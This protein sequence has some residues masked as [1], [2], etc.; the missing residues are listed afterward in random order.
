MYS[1]LFFLH[2]L[3]ELPTVTLSEMTTALL[4]EH[5]NL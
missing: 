4:A 5:E 3:A 2:H 1:P